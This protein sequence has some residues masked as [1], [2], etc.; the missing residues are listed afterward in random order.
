[1]ISREQNIL[2]LERLL[3]IYNWVVE[4]GFGSWQAT[5]GLLQADGEKLWE[6][7]QSNP[8]MS[9]EEFIEIVEMLMDGE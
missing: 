1:M 9:E 2:S 4:R 8:Q 7:I 5:I 3:N 6:A